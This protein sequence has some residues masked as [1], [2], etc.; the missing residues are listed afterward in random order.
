VRTYALV[1]DALGSGEDWL[2]QQRSLWTQRLDQLDAFLLSQR[3]R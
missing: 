2:A 3:E 1:P